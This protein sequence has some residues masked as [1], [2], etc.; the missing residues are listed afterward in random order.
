M[1][2]PLWSSGQ[3]LQN[4]PRLVWVLLPQQAVWCHSQ[5][6]GRECHQYLAEVQSNSTNLLTDA[7]NM[8]TYRVNK[9]LCPFDWIGLNWLNG[10][11]FLLLSVSHLAC[12]LSTDQ[13]RTLVI[14]RPVIA[15]KFYVH[16]FP[17]VWVAGIMN[18][19]NYREIVHSSVNL[20]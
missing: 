19:S 14:R 16:H 10:C 4:F 5:G 6:W 13:S 18:V 1:Q 8:Q 2:E 9:D 12:P 3:P 20:S 7:K 11:S 15:H 17:V